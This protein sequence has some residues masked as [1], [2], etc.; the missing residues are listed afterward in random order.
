MLVKDYMMRHPILIGP[1]MRVAEAH[2]L[3][4]ENK[5]RH[6]PVVGDGKRLLGLVTWHRL[7][8]PPERLAS[9]DVWEITR[10]LA[11]LRVGKVMVTPPDLRTIEP[12]ATLEE[13]ADIMIRH[14]VGGLPV[15]DA[16]G[17]GIVVGL[18]TDIDLL[19]E[20]QNLLG[21]KDDG[22]RVVVRIPNRRGEYSRLAR[23]ISERGWGIMAMGSTRAP[24]HADMWDV[25]LKVRHC[26]RDE[27][28]ALIGT[29]DGQQVIDIRETSSAHSQAAE[30]A[31][32][33]NAA[34]RQ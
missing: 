31:G 22:W 1:E 34:A 9:L 8:I 33:A 14:N 12:D 10:Y 19:V 23:A 25:V 6:L 13:A 24:R 2:Q 29:L 15:V 20:L 5:V 30:A 18:L 21:A 7:S 16:A 28:L 3:M 4:A 11:D 32:G 27:L 17:G 26:S